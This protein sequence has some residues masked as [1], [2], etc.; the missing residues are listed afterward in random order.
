MLAA[1]RPAGRSVVTPSIK[2]NTISN[3]TGVS[4]LNKEPN[5][6]ISNQQMDEL[7]QE[8]SFLLSV[9]MIWF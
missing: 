2:A 9:F 3:H 8:V 7:T 5:S 6:Q 1:T 4:K